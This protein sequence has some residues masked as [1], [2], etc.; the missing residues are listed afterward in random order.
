[1]KREHPLFRLLYLAFAIGVLQAIGLVG[2]ELYRL[3]TLHR[4]VAQ[5][6][7]ENEALWQRARE[8]EAELNAARSPEALEA[9]ARRLGLVKHDETLYA[10]TPH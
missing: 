2:F 5:L 7:A 9:T 8:L 1:M 3:H 4:Y 10:R 6:E